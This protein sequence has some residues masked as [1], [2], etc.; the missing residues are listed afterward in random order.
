MAFTPLLLLPL[1]ERPLLSK[2]KVLIM[3][4]IDLETIGFII[5]SFLSPFLKALLYFTVGIVFLPILSRR[6]VP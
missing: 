2:T 1:F 3:P 4:F 5:F 6:V